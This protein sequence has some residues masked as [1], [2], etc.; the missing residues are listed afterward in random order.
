MTG[1]VV[2]GVVSKTVSG[3]S[4]MF[5]S[6]DIANGL[7]LG[8]YVVTDMSS[9]Q[10]LVGELEQGVAYYFRVAAI[11]SVGKGMHVLLLVLLFVTSFVTSLFD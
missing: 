11:N 7:P 5:N 3:V 9:L 2:S 10:V 8:E 1:T 4:P 6:L